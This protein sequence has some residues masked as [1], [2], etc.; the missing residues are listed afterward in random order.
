MSSVVEVFTCVGGKGRNRGAIGTGQGCLKWRFTLSMGPART[1]VYSNEQIATILS[2]GFF[3]TLNL[4]K[5][6]TWGCILYTILF[7][8]QIHSLLCRLKIN[9]VTKNWNMRLFLRIMQTF[10]N[11]NFSKS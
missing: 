3:H 7:L 11:V 8:E 2:K 5:H 1:E 9:H 10:Y 6:H 4:Q